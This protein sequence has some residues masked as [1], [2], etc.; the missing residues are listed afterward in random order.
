MYTPDYLLIFVLLPAN[1]GYHHV[2]LLPLD[3]S[4]EG[5][6]L[7]SYHAPAQVDLVYYATSVD[8]WKYATYLTLA[9]AGVAPT[10][11]VS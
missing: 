10:F 5:L 2:T 7:Y 1:L 6:V 11:A 9:Q 4:P 3:T 8:H